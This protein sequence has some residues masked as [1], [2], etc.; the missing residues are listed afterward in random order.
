MVYILNIPFYQLTNN[1]FYKELKYATVELV[2]P[3]GLA[4]IM[5]YFYFAIAGTP[6]ILPL[7]VPKKYHNFE[8]FMKKQFDT[9][10][11]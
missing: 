9:T 10:G 7:F 11:Y 3:I 2:S 8:V 5:C 4:T 1:K 6:M